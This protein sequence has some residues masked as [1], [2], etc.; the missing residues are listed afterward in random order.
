MTIAPSLRWTAFALAIVAVIDPR[1][2][3]PHRARPAVRVLSG[4]D[5]N[6]DFALRGR[7]AA[8][9]FTDANG[10]EVATVATRDVAIAD[11]PTTPLNVVA[12]NAPDVS[13]ERAVMPETRVAGQAVTIAITARGRHIA[14]RI[15]E[16]RLDDGGL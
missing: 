11:L 10:A 6:R 13:I 16:L 14:G 8:A 15:S 5:R 7:L 9:G 3:V 12:G 1:V 4:I 2:P